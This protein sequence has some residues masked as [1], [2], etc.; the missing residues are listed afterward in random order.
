MD[1]LIKPKLRLEINKGWK[2]LVL[3]LLNDIDKIDTEKLI[4]INTIKEKFG[5]LRFYIDNTLQEVSYKEEVYKLIEEAEKKSFEICEICGKAGVPRRNC[6]WI[7]TLCE[8]HY[9]EHYAQEKD[10]RDDRDNEKLLGSG[11]LQPQD[12]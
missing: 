3:N 5:G 11:H 6:W 7:K 12:I 8:D 10:L 2:D 9:V 4:K 1:Q